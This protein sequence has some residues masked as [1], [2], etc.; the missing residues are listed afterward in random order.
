MIVSLMLIAAVLA[1]LALG[2]LVAYG[3]CQTMFRIFRVHATSVSR[4]S[5]ATPVVRAVAKG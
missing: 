4:Q 5:A 3:V 2:V 1:S